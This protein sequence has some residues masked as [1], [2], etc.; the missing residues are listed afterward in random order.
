MN[1]KQRII[2]ATISSLALKGYEASSVRDIA[3]IV[4]VQSSVL[5][6][7]FQNKES[8]LREA[9]NDI[10]I[11]L[12]TAT[13]R[14]PKNVS[15]RQY[16][17][18]HLLYQFKHR[19][20]IV[21]LLQYYMAVTDDFPIS[22]YGYIPAQAYMHMVT[23]LQMNDVSSTSTKQSLMFRAKGIQ[24]MVDGFLIEYAARS[25]SSSELTK[26]VKQLT[27]F[28]T[29]DLSATKNHDRRASYA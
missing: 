13:E 10:V 28:I 27:N 4:G 25:L 9:R 12:H 23:Y 18:T 15:P 6:Y 14:M 1:T 24:H 8:L 19:I 16:L 11:R 7:Y 26:L 2:S 3:A 20:E 29:E 22:K 5:Y 17:L 21:A